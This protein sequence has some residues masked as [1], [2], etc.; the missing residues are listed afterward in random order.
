MCPNC[1]TTINLEN[2]RETDFDM[3]K[4]AT[5]REARTFTELLHI[6]NLSRKTLSLRLKEMCQN[7]ILVK[8]EGTYN[9]NGGFPSE[10][11]SRKPAGGFRRAFNDK[12]VRTGLM[13][14]ALILFSS[15]SSY[16]LAS[17]L[18]PKAT[19][20]EP[21]ALG[22]FTLALDV[23]NV[24]NLYSWQ[25]AARFNSS[26]VKVQ[27]IMSRDFVG[28]DPDTGFPLFM[29]FTDTRMDYPTLLLGGTLL[30][31]VQGKDG[32]GRLA[33]IAFVYF[34]KDFA[35]PEIVFNEKTFLLDP[36]GA[37]IPIGDSTLTLRMI[38]KE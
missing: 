16:V 22:T 4:N 25:V 8:S 14:V 26:E 38:R 12:R 2:R 20:H 5:E 28:Y 35:K 7:G 19:N 23:S 31:D 3:I 37:S 30:G 6:T 21:V 13:L 29:N 1:G 32:T 9:L 33:T 15:T 10:E 27:E 36:D 11:A 24:E 34:V 17:F 18:M